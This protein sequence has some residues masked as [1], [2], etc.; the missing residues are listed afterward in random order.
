MH[1]NEILIDSP[2]KEAV[3][4]VEFFKEVFLDKIGELENKYHCGISK[5][6]VRFKVFDLP[7]NPVA[8]QNGNQKKFVCIEVEDFYKSQLTKRGQ[9]FVF[10]VTGACQASIAHTNNHE[11]IDL[12]AK[13][14]IV[15]F[16]WIKYDIGHMSGPHPE[17]KSYPYME[18]LTWYYD[19]D[20]TQ[21]GVL[22]EYFK[23]L[24]QESKYIKKCDIKENRCILSVAQE[25]LCDF[26][27]N[28]VCPTYSLLQL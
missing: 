1:V 17:M 10:P 9:P 25:D 21:Q 18:T 7:N 14:T 23:K 16:A 27:F 22:E 2:A 6:H 11:D 19:Y 12:L 4:D 24:S 26:F 28:E 13:R 5:N 15:V 20:K 3:R 8:V